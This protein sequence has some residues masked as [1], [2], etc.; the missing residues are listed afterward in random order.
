[1]GQMGYWG[2]HDTITAEAAL[3]KTSVHKSDEIF[4]G[5]INDFALPSLRT[6]VHDEDTLWDLNWILDDPPIGPNGWGGFT[7][8]FYSPRTQKGLYGWY[9]PATHKARD[10]L[11]KIDRSWC[12]KKPFSSLSPSDQKKVYDNFGRISHLIQDMAV[13]S[14]TTNDWH[15]FRK[16]FE[17][18]IDQHW[19]QI[20]NS[21]YF[22]SSVTVDSYLMAPTNSVPTL[23]RRLP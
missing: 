11:R 10:Y 4:K 6:G 14:H 16:P 2:G 21:P 23:T 13:P 15:P 5:W 9:Y 1:L 8:H 22:E 19:D 20:V 12:R 17:T 3:L 18:Y 7:E